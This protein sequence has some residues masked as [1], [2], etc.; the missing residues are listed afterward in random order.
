[1]AP[2]SAYSDQVKETA[3]VLFRETSRTSEE[4]SRLTG[5]T[6]STL[7]G[8]LQKEPKPPHRGGPGTKPQ[9]YN[10]AKDKLIEAQQAE[11]EALR[12]KVEAI[13]NEPKNLDA[14][15]NDILN[16]I[17][18]TRHTARLGELA[19][20]AK[21][22]FDIKKDEAPSGDEARVVEYQIPAGEERP[23]VAQ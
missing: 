21:V 13:K 18:V 20:T 6:H 12:A 4:I 9:G 10:E 7:K 14:M 11:I 23:P 5:V 2:K 3:L 17:A 19:T 22:L 1:M 8:W 15:F 16:Q